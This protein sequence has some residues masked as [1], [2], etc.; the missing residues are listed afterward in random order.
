MGSRKSS[1]II[2]KAK[3]ILRI[4]LVYTHIFTSRFH[5][6]IQRILFMGSVEFER[7]LPNELKPKVNV[8]LS[9]QKHLAIY[10]H[11]FEK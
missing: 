4:M 3:K 6:Q 7:I 10:N 8:K 5:L 11:L 2:L 9:L 1:G